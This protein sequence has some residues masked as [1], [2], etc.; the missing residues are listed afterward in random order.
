[1]STSNYKFLNNATPTDLETVFA[2]W[3]NVLGTGGLYTFGS[4]TFGELGDG[5]IVDK[6]SPV[7]VGSLTNWKQVASGYYHI[8]AV[9]TDGTLWTF[10]RNN[11]GQ[12]GIGTTVS[13]LSPVQVGTLTNWAQVA[14]GIYH[15]AAILI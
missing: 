5:T 15:T 6:S 13:K 3:A 1:M 7:Q 10:G 9:K 8:A 4:D 14:G 11:Y 2:T 12:L